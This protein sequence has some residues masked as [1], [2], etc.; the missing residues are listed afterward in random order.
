MKDKEITAVSRILVKWD[1]LGP[2]ARFVEDLDDYK[3]KAVDILSSIEFK[4][5]M[6]SI[7]IIVRDV[8][9]QYFDLDLSLQDCKEPANE[10]SKVIRIFEINNRNHRDNLVEIR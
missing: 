4:P 7:T 3:T 1:P 8:L 9:N 10:I 2:R 5:R 6:D